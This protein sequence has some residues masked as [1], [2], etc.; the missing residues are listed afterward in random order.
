MLTISGNIEAPKYFDS[1][2]QSYFLDPAAT[3][4]GLKLAG[5]IELTG[6]GTIASTANNN[7]T[8]D[9]G[10]GTVIIGTG[11]GKLDAGTVDPPYTINGK[12]YATYVP[13]MVGIKEETTGTV[14]TS[15][16]IPEKGG[17][18][19][20]LDF[21]GQQE[22]SDL[23]LFS[24][25]TALKKHIGQMTVLLSA[26]SNT[27]SWYEV[28]PESLRL[29]IFT[30]RP[31]SVSY[32]L[33]APRFDA[34]VWQNTRDDGG[35][36]GHIINDPDEPLL[37]LDETGYLDGIS[38]PEKARP[39]QATVLSPLSD[40]PGDGIAVKLG[41]GQTLGI[42]NNEGS[43][44]A[45]FDSLGNATFSG[46]L[47]AENL[48]LK[49]DA[50]ISGTLY[51]DR[52]ITRFGDIGD[53][54]T[55]TISAT[56][57]TNTITNITQLI[58]SQ[59]ATLTPELDATSSALLALLANYESGIMNQGKNQILD[60]LLVSGPLIIGNEGITATSDTLY[61]EKNKT[62]NLDIIAGTLVV[63]TAGDVIISGNLAVSGNVAIGGVLGVDTISPSNGQLTI[64]LTRYGGTGT[65]S[66]ELVN[67][68]G[69]FLIEREGREVASITAS[70]SASFAGDVTASG[71]GI[72]RKLVISDPARSL[73]A[74]QGETLQDA[75]PSAG[76]ATLTAG[77]REVTIPNTNVS[78]SSLIYVTPVTSTDN[79]VLYINKKEAGV[80]FTVAI[81]QALSRD[82]QF[83]WWIIN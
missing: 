46:K 54:R 80:N 41:G 76:T 10:S 78:V 40:E 19:A 25:V 12:K 82:I 56:Y 55:G 42:Y 51:A 59:S 16:F 39:F 75:S 49:A 34:E 67:R 43:P 31:S 15:V 81:D 6:G 3:G 66:G 26:A 38:Q 8:I 52:I 29:T 68:F 74:S 2:D 23:W 35:S 77:S 27:R 70:G 11:T 58:A 21:L 60:S 36:V 48:E 63:N 18:R 64:D 17:Y 53:L 24:K 32:R 47:S 1:A 13:S 33:S 22:G 61:I 62:A 45:S 71:S 72:F 73:L 28:D 14:Y 57:I 7:I 5:N 30:S 4:T 44:T 69:R 79:Q 37:T 65:E 50:T 9:A 83:S 20:T